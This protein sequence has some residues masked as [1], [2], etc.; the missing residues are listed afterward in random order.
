MN[1]FTA[2]FIGESNIIDGIMKQDYEVIFEGH[3]FMCVD[4]GFDENEP[5]DVVIR[6]EDIVLHKKK[7]KINGIVDA[8]TFKG[9]HYEIIVMVKNKE[10]IVHSTTKKEVGDAVSLHFEK[11][12]I[13]V[14]R[15]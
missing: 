10:Y 9:V 14:M 6:P 12:D 5:V 4:F 7:G 8:I 3:S 2:D 11:E 13:H 1:R 15:K